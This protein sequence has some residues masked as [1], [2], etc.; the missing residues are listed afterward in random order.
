MVLV[1]MYTQ[2]VSQCLPVFDD[3]KN[4][5]IQGGIVKHPVFD[6]FFPQW[7]PTYFEAFTGKIGG[8]EESNHRTSWDGHCVPSSLYRKNC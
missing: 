3:K 6:D 7:M 1:V 5:Q 8:K 2:G 4:H